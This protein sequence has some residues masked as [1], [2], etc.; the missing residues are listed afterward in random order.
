M[1]GS[2]T[3]HTLGNSS[4]DADASGDNNNAGGQKIIK[5]FDGDNP[6]VDFDFPSIGI[7][8][9]DRAVFNLFDQ[10]LRFQTTQ[11]KESKKV[12]VVFASGERFAL[13]RRKNPIRDKNNA[14]ILPLISIIR[15]EVDFSADQGGKKTA[16]SFRE[17]PSY[18]I[19]RR[20]SEKDREYQ[21]VINK[22][23]LRNQ[24][25]VSSRN[26]FSAND[27]VPG[28]IAPP[29]YAAS[30]RNGNNLSFTNNSELI[31]LNQNLGNNIFEIIEIPYPDFISVSYEVTFWTQ[32][33]TQA[34]QMIETLLFNF[35][36]QGEEITMNTEDG[37]ELVAFFKPPFNNN[38]NFDNYSDEERIIKHSIMLTVPGYI[39][40]PKHSGIPNLARS[41]F[42]APM[43]DFGY[44]NQ[45][46]KII[47]NNKQETKKEK[48]IKNVLTDLV[49][50]AEENQR[51]DL[52]VVVEEIIENPFTGEGN[53][54]YSKIRHRNQRAGETVASSL[55]MTE[56]ERQNE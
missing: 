53:I 7:E 34:N 19:K 35:E 28:N 40:N 5:K 41:Y 45:N 17:Q 32:Y 50:P 49:N 22:M 56:I 26:G 15:N 54:K 47:D 20:L 51:G 8:N 10:K 27:I 16:I 13:T 18:I 42:S 43:I 30:R 52:S 21:N 23:G 38:A 25:N 46:K 48:F 31:N 12:P 39:L 44:V 55:I 2:S 37:F 24:K 9:I 3:R 29:D 14:L 1:P 11:K 36:G 33:I 6:P 4:T